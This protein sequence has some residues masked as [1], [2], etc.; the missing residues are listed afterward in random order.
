VAG[1]DSALAKAPN[2]PHVAD[3]LGRRTINGHRLIIASLLTLTTSHSYLSGGHT[4]TM[5]LVLRSPQAPSGP[6]DALDEAIRD[7]RSILSNHDLASLRK[8][9]EVPPE[10][11]VMQFTAR[12]DATRRSKKGRSIASRLYTVL[13][14]V[15]DFSTIVD[16]F[17]SSR[18]EIA[19]LVWGSI[20]MTMLVSSK[21][22][23]KLLASVWH[24]QDCGQFYVVL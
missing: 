11:A 22:C 16:T 5:A 13:Q 19:A 23:P 1:H 24:C 20:K 18:P 7:F 6:R 21:G 17:I 12:L 9:K 14:T 3:H 10:Q 8:I 2:A 4:N 15:R